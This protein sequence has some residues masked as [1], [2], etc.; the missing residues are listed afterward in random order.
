MTRELW[1]ISQNCEHSVRDTF[2]SVEN[3]DTNMY[4]GHPEEMVEIIKRG[5]QKMA[6][7]MTEKLVQN[8]EIR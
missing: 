2:I 5:R 8:S 6:S 4:G 3:V 7:Y 1:P